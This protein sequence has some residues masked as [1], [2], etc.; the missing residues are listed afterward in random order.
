[1]TRATEYLIRVSGAQKDGHPIQR[2]E[3]NFGEAARSMDL[4]HETY[5]ENDIVMYKLEEKEVATF[6]GKKKRPVCPRGCEG[7]RDNRPVVVRTEKGLVQCS[8]CGY[9]G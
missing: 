1:M 3:Y 9:L 8:V 4:L 5:P 7:T 6:K 2:I